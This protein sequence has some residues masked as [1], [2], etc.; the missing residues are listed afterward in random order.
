MRIAYLHYHLKT[1]GVTTVIR[2]QVEAVKGDCETVVFA[3]SLPESDFPAQVISVDGLG[4]DSE[5]DRH[6][7]PESAAGYILEAL[8]RQR[9]KHTVRHRVT[10]NQYERGA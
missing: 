1:G 10:V 9:K 5:S 2:Q 8:Y 7:R 6:Y 3:G 4:Y